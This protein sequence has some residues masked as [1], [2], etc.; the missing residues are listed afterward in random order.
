MRISDSVNAVML[1]RRRR[2]VTVVWLWNERGAIGDR[3][4]PG[5]GKISSGAGPGL[6]YTQYILVSRIM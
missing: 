2:L 1:A 6:E 5:V 3:M 4:D